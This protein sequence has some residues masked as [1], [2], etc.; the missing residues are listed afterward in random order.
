VS[1]SLSRRRL[2]LSSDY[3]YPD[4]SAPVD[5]PLFHISSPHAR[6]LSEYLHLYDAFNPFGESSS[7]ENEERKIEMGGEKGEE[8][9]VEERKGDKGVG[10]RRSK[11]HDEDFE[12]DG[13]GGEGGGGESLRHRRL[14]NTTE[15]PTLYNPAVCLIAGESVLF[16][17]SNRQYPVY[18]KDSLLNTNPQFDYSAFRQL[19]ALAAT[20]VTV[21]SFAFT[22]SSAG[23]WSSA[24]YIYT[25][26]CVCVSACVRI[27]VCVSVCLSV[28][29][30]VCIIPAYHIIVLQA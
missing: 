25:C 14:S 29:A 18:L 27:S 7:Q 9:E 20:S 15:P 28:S 16:D 11:S 4:H 12:S 22:F 10:Q 2:L 5:P 21:S 17:V 6:T 30:S 26:V 3:K 19:S 1:A 8:G 13:G 24:V 23:E